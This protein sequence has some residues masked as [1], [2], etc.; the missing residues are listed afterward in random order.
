VGVS[1]WIVVGYLV[2]L[3]ALL[4]VFPVPRA[5]RLRLVAVAVPLV[6]FLL[7][8]TA[9]PLSPAVRH[10]R[11]WLPLPC[12]VLC[13]WLSGLFFL[14]PQEQFERRFSAFDRRTRAWFG[15]GP[16]AADAPRIVLEWLELAYFSCYLMLPAGMAALVLAGRVDQWDRYWSMVLLAECASYGVLPWIRTRPPWAVRPYS[17]MRNRRGLFR[18]LN[19]LVVRYMSTQANTFPSGHAAGAFAAAFAVASVWPAAGAAFFL[20]AVSI[21]VGSVVGEYHYAGDAVTGALTAA[22]AWGVVTAI[23]G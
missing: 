19:L 10:I 13:Y 6:A 21:A 5:S 14:S 9:L 12:I 18:R 2:Y 20:V 16:S 22:A 4:A 17:P 7:I 1:E 23:F 11:P 3:H 15:A 8:V